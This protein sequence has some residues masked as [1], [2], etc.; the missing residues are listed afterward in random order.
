MAPSPLPKEG[1]TDGLDHAIGRLREA[2]VLA[3]VRRN[4]PGMKL[5]SVLPTIR[6]GETFMDYRARL[7]GFL[8]PARPKTPN[9]GMPEPEISF[10]GSLHRKLIAGFRWARTFGISRKRD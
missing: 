4:H 7:I 10:W 3:E 6:E 5:K 2:I 1:T 8:L 9:R